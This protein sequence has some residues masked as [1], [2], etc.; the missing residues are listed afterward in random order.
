EPPGIDAPD[1]EPGENGHPQM[2]FTKGHDALLAVLTC[3]AP[4]GWNVYYFLH[5]VEFFR[6][7]SLLTDGAEEGRAAA[8]HDAL[9]PAAT[10][11]GAA[12]LML[13]AVDVE[14]MLE[15][16][17]AALDIG[18]ILQGRAARRDGVMQDVANL[19]RQPLQPRTADLAR[20]RQGRDARPIQGL[21][22]I[23]VAQ[24]RHDALVQQADLDVLR[25]AREGLGQV[26]AREGVAQRLRPQFGEPGVALD[27]LSRD[28]PHEAEA[29]C[30]GITQPRQHAAAISR[31]A[32]MLMLAD[33]G[34][35][36]LEQAGGDAFQSKAA[37][38]S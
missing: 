31:Q 32:H 35:V 23:D 11:F 15:I 28:Q 25:L 12:R 7:H 38:H 17:L 16:A 14:A 24:T 37:G 6:H 8:L 21:A 9:D 4:D 10:A 30:I 29:P 13:A 5:N 22:H 1:R 20:R 34:G 19:D 26:R 2:F 3:V 18:E 36:R 33:D 27:R